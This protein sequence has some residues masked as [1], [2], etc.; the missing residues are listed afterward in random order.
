[1]LVEEVFV[2]L[3]KDKVRNVFVEIVVNFIFECVSFLLEVI[4]LISRY[5]KVL[6]LIE[7]I[8]IGKFENLSIFFLN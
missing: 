7:L 5:L 6:E 3:S 8:K 2:F 4:L 1:M